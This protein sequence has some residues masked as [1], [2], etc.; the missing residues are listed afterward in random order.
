M[1]KNF[2]WL[3]VLAVASSVGFAQTPVGTTIQNQASARFI[4][5]ANQ[6]RTTTS[7]EVFTV[8]QQIYGLSI[9]PNGTTTA[10]GQTRTALPGAPVYFS[11]TITNTGNGT[12]T[13]NLTTPQGTTGTD[14][15]TID[16]TSITLVRDDNCDGTIDPGEPTVTSVSLAMGASACVLVSASVPGTAVN[17]DQADINLSGTSAGDNT[18]TDTNN[19]ATAVA[20]TAGSLDLVKSASP[21]GPLS[22][23]SV[24]T[25]TLTG[26]N[27][28]GSG[29]YAVTGV[30]TYGGSAHNGILVSDVIPSGLT[31]E[32]AT[33]SGSAGAGT[34]VKLYSVDSGSTWATT[35]P[36]SGV[37]AV[38]ILIEGSGQFFPQNAQYS[39]SFQARVPASAAA[40]SSFNNTASVKYSGDSDGLANGLGESISSNTTANLVSSTYK[41]AIGGTAATAVDGADT[42]TIASATAGSTVSFTSTLQ[43]T[44]DSSD[45]FNLSLGTSS[46][47]VCVIY[48]PD[49]ITP[50]SG[51]VGPM[52]ANATMS[53][54]VKCTI[55]AGQ[56]TGGNV[57]LTATSVK[58]PSGTVAATGDGVDA[59]TLAV[60]TVTSGFGLDMAAPNAATDTPGVA[61]INAGGETANDTLTNPAAINPGSSVAIPFQVKNAGSNPD[62]YTFSATLPS[63]WTVAYYPDSNCDGTADSGAAP[64][65][66]SGLLNASGSDSLCVVAVVQVPTGTTPGSSTVTITA[67]ST[68]LPSASDAVQTSVTVNSVTGFTFDPDRAGTVTTPGTITYSHNLLNTGNLACTVSIPAISSSNGWVYQFSTN[69]GTSWSSS[70]SGLSLAANTGSNTVMVRVIVPSGEPIGRVE[71]KVITATC[72]YGSSLTATA[73]VTDTTTVVGGDLR[74]TKTVDKTTAIPGDNLVYTIL[75]ENIGTGN[76]KQTVISDPLP[77]YTDFVSLAA[78]TTLTG[79][80]VV[81]KDGTTWK[82]FASVDADSNGSI[83]AAEWSN[84][85]TGFGSALIA[86][87][88]VYVG[89]DTNSDTN[90]TTADTMAPAASTTLTFTVKVQ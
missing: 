83:S 40:G 17:G 73:Q 74:L 76:I 42:Q 36:A 61:G 5:S 4:D 1:R 44:G 47:G 14:G 24:I 21:T 39:M 69:G 66:N 26:Q 3:C 8:V 32:A 46:I 15:D 50:V 71:S 43:N 6:P 31:F 90:I 80:I 57:T 2:W 59:T 88:S 54:V 52:A 60:T 75:A 30:V 13:I 27:R 78:T 7:N 89:V 64:I 67:T 45:S 55:P 82:T 35:E 9:T 20:T 72:D 56:T 87:G 28:G 23:N 18:K 68:T 29:V 62:T 77:A 63:G 84:A 51:A 48:Q 34:I 58:N 49:G 70:V 38:A 79:T 10:P 65:T 53:V 22:A 86:G 81:S 41:V 37:N 85:T 16:L 33:L 19:W 11:Y 12:D 25:Y